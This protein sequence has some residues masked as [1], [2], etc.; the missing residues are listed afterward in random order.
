A[1]LCRDEELWFHVDGAFGALAR[2]SPRLA[3]LVAGMAR[4][5]SL[6]FD[7]HK[8]MYLP[9]EIACVLVRDPEMHRQTFAVEAAYLSRTSRG[10]VAGGMPFAHRGIELTRSF[11]ALKVW[12]SLKA[13]GLRRFISI[14]E[15]KRE[16][17][18]RHGD[19]YAEDR[20]ERGT[21]PAPRRTGRQGYGPGVVD[22]GVAQHRL[23]PVCAK[24]T[25]RR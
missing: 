20:A 13:H 16:H 1:D 4:A 3:S 11:R 24:G 19:L 7:L 12:L 22:P 5:D 18:Q 2:L 14:I 17:P 10:V 23:L 25:V 21:R 9:F 6:A 15:Q 8:W